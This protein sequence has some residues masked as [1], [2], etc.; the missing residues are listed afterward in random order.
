MGCYV[1]PQ[2][3]SKGT[4]YFEVRRIWRQRRLFHSCYVFFWSEDKLMASPKICLYLTG[5]L[6][7]YRYVNVGT[8]GLL[9]CHKH[10]CCCPICNVSTHF[11]EFIEHFILKYALT[12]TLDQHVSCVFIWCNGGGASSEHRIVLYSPMCHHHPYS[13]SLWHFPFVWTSL[14]PRI[15]MALNTLNFIINP[16]SQP[17]T[18]LCSLNSKK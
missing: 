17:Q 10:N 15:K 18:S 13:C 9:H 3:L 4:C 7:T 11:Y 8:H 1:A 12:M 6:G 14:I 16:K 2:P 5:L